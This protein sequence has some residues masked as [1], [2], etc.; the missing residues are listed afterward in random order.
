[1]EKLEDIKMKKEK[2]NLEFFNTFKTRFTPD[3][4]VS[5]YDPKDFGVLRKP[6]E[7]KCGKYV[8]R[9]FDYNPDSEIK[10]AIVVFAHGMWSTVDS[11]NQDICYLCQNGFEVVSF[12]DI[13]VGP[14]DGKNTIALGNTLK[15]VDAV[16][17]YVKSQE[18]Y[19]SRKI[20]IM[21]HSWGAHAACNIIYYHPNIEKVV[22]MAP[23]ISG[24]RLAKSYSPTHNKFLSFLFMV[25]DFFKVG[26]YATRSS[27][28]SLKH[29]KGKVLILH[30]KNDPLV[31]FESHTKLVMEKF[32]N[33]N[34]IINENRGHNPNYTDESISNLNKYLT[35][36]KNLNP[37]EKEE[38]KKK[39]NFLKMGELDPIVMDKIVDFLKS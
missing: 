20:Y 8:M 32:P 18:K 36:S 21:G 30:S 13:G 5:N 29:Y 6:I 25:V 10:D 23:Y 28:K 27:L 14:S 39:T 7:T 37:E 17:K 34:Y 22:A 12:N 16:I 24:Y 33:L 19:K 38:L 11:Y 3:P 9:G 1:M 26:H 2:R 15:S 4:L 31:N 35:E